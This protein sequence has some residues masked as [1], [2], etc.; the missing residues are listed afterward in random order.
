MCYY[1]LGL[2]NRAIKDLG[3]AIKK[4]NY[5]DEVWLEEP[6]PVLDE[7][8]LL[9]IREFEK[10]VVLGRKELTGM[11]AVYRRT[12]QY[13]KALD[14]LKRL[15]RIRKKDPGILQQIS[16]IYYLMG[17]PKSALLFLLKAMEL[18]NKVYERFS[19]LLP[20]VAISDLF[21]SLST[22]TSI[23]NRNKWRKN[24]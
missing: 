21:L 8:D 15:Y 10:R 22:D 6:S 14:I 9:K 23:F 13:R 24:D 2:F 16:Q 11:V 5:N 19:N 3:E 12:F 4:N 17:C 7:T 18:D 20:S 1:K